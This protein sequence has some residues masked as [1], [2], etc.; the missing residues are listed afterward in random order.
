M[1]SSAVSSGA[2]GGANFVRSVAAK[3]EPAVVT[4]HVMS[5]IERQPMTVQDLYGGQDGGGGTEMRRGAGSG[6][7]IS[8][9]GY[10]I[11]NN[12]VVAGAQSVTVE[13]GGT[14]YDAR[15]VGADPLSDIAVVKITPAAGATFPVADLG[16][17]DDVRVGDWAIAVGNPL[18]IGATVTLGIVSAIG[19]RGPH[20]Q[21]DA[22]STV[23]QTDAAI[24][25][26]NSG[27]ALADSDGKVIGIN[28]A[29]LSPTGSFIGIGFAIPINAAHKIAD[30]LIANGRVIRPYLGISY[31]P[32]K[33]V[34]PDARAKAGI[35]PD[36]TSGVVVAQV[37]PDTPAAVAGLTPGDVI[38]QADGKPL[39]DEDTLNGIIIAH[40]VGDTLSLQIQRGG[41]AQAV[42]IILRERPASY[43]NAPSPE[44]QPGPQ[45]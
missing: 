5:A 35:S 42:S 16:N 8:P 41:Q 43:S 22:A 3:V 17:S 27:G 36:L 7:I 39:A 33:S 19:P 23:L 26:G 30:Q 25:P 12:H 28:E 40:K 29:I 32:V 21:G 14:G 4:V 20:L 18:D 44:P 45:Q 10:V 6:V 2:G 15:V 13:V 37:A 1:T 38:L 31:V 11:T 24:N 34:P 9:D